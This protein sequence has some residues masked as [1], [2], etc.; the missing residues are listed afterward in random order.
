MHI[1]P[2][3]FL[4]GS[5]KEQALLN[6]CAVL[7]LFSPEWCLVMA[8]TGI[9]LPLYNRRRVQKLTGLDLS[10]GMLEEAQAK[11][12]H[13]G[14]GLQISLQQGT[15]TGKSTQSAL[16]EACCEMHTLSLSLENNSQHNSLNTE[17][18]STH[19]QPKQYLHSI[20]ST[21]FIAS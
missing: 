13:D 9:N 15:A 16:C 5:K 6:T 17:V 1:F 7:A 14:R 10:Q 4:I 3:F 20:A 8:G 12:Q 21:R 11:L 18:H 19:Q 2:C